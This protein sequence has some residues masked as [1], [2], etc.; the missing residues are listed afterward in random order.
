VLAPPHAESTIRRAAAE[1]LSRGSER[2]TAIS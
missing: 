2:F 1:D